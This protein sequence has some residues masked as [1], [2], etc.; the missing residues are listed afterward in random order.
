MREVESTFEVPLAHI[1]DAANHRPSERSLGTRTLR[2][3][4]IPFGPYNIWGATAAMLLELYRV[5][6]GEEV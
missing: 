4:E 5:V 1:L 3:H 2:V 6:A